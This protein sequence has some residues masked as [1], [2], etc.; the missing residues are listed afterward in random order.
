METSGEAFPK[1]FRLRKRREYLQAQRVGRRL[2]SPH[3]IVYA[4]PNGSR[5]PRLGITVSRKVG[6]AHVR[7]R[8]K[9]L[10][11]EVFRRARQEFPSG[12]D[13]V[14]VAKSEIAPP[15][16]LQTRDELLG[17]VRRFDAARPAPR[18]DNR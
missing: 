14:V 11:R 7:N 15:D 6:K 10:V 5:R 8:L 4:R 1:R 16:L 2:T 9:R 18:R 13:F 3:F 12:M 17:L